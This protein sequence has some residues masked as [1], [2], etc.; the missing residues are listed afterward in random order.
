MQILRDAFV[1][2]VLSSIEDTSSITQLSELFRRFQSYL[3]DETIYSAFTHQLEFFKFRSVDSLITKMCND[4][5][6]DIEMERVILCVSATTPKLGEFDVM[7][8]FQTKTGHIL[9]DCVD[10]LIRNILQKTNGNK[11][12]AAKILGIETSDFNDLCNLKYTLFI[13]KLKKTRKSTK[14]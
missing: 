14:K 6:S 8:S 5:Q 1:K 2:S 12:E 9:N 10:E 11:E 3:Y 7:V 4:L 13:K